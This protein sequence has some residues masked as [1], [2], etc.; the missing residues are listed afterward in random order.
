MEDDSE[1]PT[2]SCSLTI[3]MFCLY[4]TCSAVSIAIAETFLSDLEHIIKAIV[5]QQ[6][7]KGVLCFIKPKLS[8]F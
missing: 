1:I 4:Y 6:I 7:C 5:F 2:V 3:A 8:L